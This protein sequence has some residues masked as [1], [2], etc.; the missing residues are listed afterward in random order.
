MALYLDGSRWESEECSVPS[1]ARGD[2]AHLTIRTKCVGPP[3]SVFLISA[4]LSLSETS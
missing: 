4:S 1:G 2:S 3:H